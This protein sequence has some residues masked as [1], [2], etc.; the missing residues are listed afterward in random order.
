[1]Q[2]ARYGLRLHTHLAAHVGEIDYCLER[3]G[4]RPVD[5]MAEVGWLGPNV[6][7]AHGIFFSAEERMR[8][9]RAGVAICHCPTSN[10]ITASGFCPVPD[11]EAAGVSVGLSVDGSSANDGSSMIGEVRQAF[12]L[13][14][15][16][17][18]VGRVSAADALRWGTVGGAACLGRP[19]IGA[20]AP[21]MQADLALFRA[22]SLAFTG[23]DDALAALVRSA[24]PRADRVM[25]AGSWIVEEGRLPGLDTAALAEA[26]AEAARGLRTRA[27]V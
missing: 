24:P 13:Q 1:M 16:V 23:A 6:W 25:V 17:H 5:Y 3:F 2:A 20:L 10:M 4:C 19:E 18:G 15:V 21:G 8:L 7:L 27:G 14:R 9:G 26:H 11:L 22:D 12:L